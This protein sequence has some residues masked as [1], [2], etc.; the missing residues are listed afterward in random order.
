M[1][2]WLDLAWS[3]AAFYAAFALIAGGFALWAAVKIFRRLFRELDDEA[4]IA[5]PH[6]GMRRPKR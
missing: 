2:S 1:G 5:I 6:V 4:E 3:A